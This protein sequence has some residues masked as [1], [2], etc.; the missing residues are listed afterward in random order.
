MK[1]ALKLLP[2]DTPSDIRGRHQH[3]YRAEIDS[4]PVVQCILRQ[5]AASFGAGIPGESESAHF[6]LSCRGRGR[7][8]GGAHGDGAHVQDEQWRGWVAQV[9]G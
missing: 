6:V 4:V 8:G 7:D 2:L 1:L 9:F 3:L 5:R